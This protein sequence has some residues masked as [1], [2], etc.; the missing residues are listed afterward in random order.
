MILPLPRPR[1]DPL[2]QVPSGN[3]TGERKMRQMSARLRAQARLPE[4]SSTRHVFMQKPWFRNRSAV[5][6]IGD[7]PSEC[8]IRPDLSG[9]AAQSPAPPA[10]RCQSPS[11]TSL[12]FSRSAS[13]VCA[14]ISSGARSSLVSTRI[15]FPAPPS[16]ATHE[17][18]HN[19]REWWKEDARRGYS[20]WT[21]VSPAAKEAKLAPRKL[22]S[23]HHCRFANSPRPPSVSEPWYRITVLATP[24]LP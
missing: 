17:L 11:S 5:D 23:D 15:M 2:V 7:I 9:R 12:F 20:C 13:Q 10:T 3:A 22:D 24:A 8:H 14:A 4:G 6:R 19:G 21:L 16:L 18:A 1:E